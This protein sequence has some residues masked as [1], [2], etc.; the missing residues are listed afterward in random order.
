MEPAQKSW[1]F[2]RIL[3]FFGRQEVK[4]PLSFMFRAIPLLTTV[5]IATFYAPISES[6]K[7]TIIK[8]SSFIF[9]VMCGFTL[10]FAWFKPRNLVYGETGHRAERKMEFGTEKKAISAVELETLRA[11]ENTQPPLL[12]DK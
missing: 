3:R 7:F 6:L 1:D 10:V 8:F 11:E 12:K 4:T 9:V 2:T 5:W